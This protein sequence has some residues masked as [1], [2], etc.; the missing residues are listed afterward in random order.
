MPVIEPR[1]ILHPTTPTLGVAIIPN[2]Q[3]DYIFINESIDK[4]NPN[5]FHSRSY[6]YNLKTHNVTAIESVLLA[7][8]QII[9]AGWQ[10]LNEEID[11][12]TQ[13]KIANKVLN[14][15]N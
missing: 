9:A 2:L 5:R 11:Q 13:A 10:R 6:L 14:L 15:A 7:K 8:G 1:S 3:G 4:L 12:E